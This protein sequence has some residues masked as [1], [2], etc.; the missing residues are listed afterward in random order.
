[1][2]YRVWLEDCHPDYQVII[3]ALDYEGFITDY[4]EWQELDEYGWQ[5]DNKS[6][7]E[8]CRGRAEM[9]IKMNYNNRNAL[10]M[11][12]TEIIEED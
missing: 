8:M 7:Y 2:I 12:K 6:E 9:V 10:R 1:M 3:N 4:M 5:F 11:L